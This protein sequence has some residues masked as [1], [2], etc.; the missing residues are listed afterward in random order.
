MDDVETLAWQYVPLNTGECSFVIMDSRK[1]EPGPP[2]HTTKE[3]C[4]A[5][6]P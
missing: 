4:S 5:Q 6:Q 2:P 3:A 1:K